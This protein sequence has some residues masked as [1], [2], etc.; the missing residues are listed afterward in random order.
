MVDECMPFLINFSCSPYY[1]YRSRRVG[2]WITFFLFL[3]IVAV[4]LSI[5]LGLRYGTD[6]TDIEATKEYA[7]TD[8]VIRSYNG[9]FCQGLGAKSTGDAPSPASNA[10][11]YLLNSRPPLVDSESFNISETAVFSSTNSYHYWNFYLN[12][13]S[14][15]SFRACYTSS[16][17]HY[18]VKF[19][20]IKGSKNHKRWLD[21]IDSDYAL[22]YKRLASECQTVDYQVQ[23]DALYFLSFYFDD[24]FVVYP[25]TLNIDF[26]FNRTVY[27]V[28][29]DNVVQNCS[30]P[31]D[32]YSG[33]SLSVPMSSGYTALL[34]LNTTLPV[35]Y[36]DGA[37]I[38]LDCQPRGWLY[39][40]VVIFTV[41]PVL[42][43]IA[44]IVT[45]VCFKMRKGKKT[46]M[47]L[48]RSAATASTDSSNQTSVA[49]TTESAFPKP[50]E[51]LGTAPPPYNPAYPPSSSGYGATT[52]A[53]LP[54]P[55]KQ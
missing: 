22:K 9:D 15:L 32:G 48:N 53:G 44:V 21:D 43:V 46:Y 12:A 29:E 33:C 47:S 1:G 37:N 18:N 6:S 7:L 24:D 10:T 14:K 26:H 34:S 19:Y 4:V 17:D 50:G 52:P 25:S 45:C 2:G 40:I 36:N 8:K 16:S 42:I 23:Q 35:N 30:F 49:N 38:K 41:V 51:N 55:Y 27:H 31:L 39:A 11:L 28:S 13:G 5:T 54:P 20:L 3:V